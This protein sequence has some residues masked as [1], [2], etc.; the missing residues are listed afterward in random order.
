MQGGKGAA[1]DYLRILRQG[2]LDRAR[3]NVERYSYTGQIELRLCDGLAR[4]AQG[5]SE[6][7]H[8]LPGMGGNMI[9]VHF[10]GCSVDPGEEL[11]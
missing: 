7:G 3:G 6:R 2:P 10:R 4:S 9:A 5:G 11:T 1:R 8:H